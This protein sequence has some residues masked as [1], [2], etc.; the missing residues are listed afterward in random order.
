[1]LVD[2]AH[3]RLQAVPS[4]AS[5]ERGLSVPFIGLSAT[6]WTR[7][8]GRLYDTLIVSATTKDLIDKGSWR[9]SVFA[10]SHPDLTG[11]RTVA[12]DY[13][14]GDLSKAMDKRE[15]VADV[16][17]TWLAKAENRRRWCSPSIARTPNPSRSSS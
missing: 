17:T 5:R 11:V 14:E 9:R 7:G 13:H 3:R 10:P 16:V 1:M 8:L 12:G 6:P 2:E 4:L 15:L